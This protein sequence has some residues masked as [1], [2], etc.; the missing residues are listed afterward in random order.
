MVN[1]AVT[2]CAE[3]KTIRNSNYKHLFVLLLQNFKQPLTQS[4]GYEL[5]RAEKLEKT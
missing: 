5:K 2:N 3:E 4:I 1:V